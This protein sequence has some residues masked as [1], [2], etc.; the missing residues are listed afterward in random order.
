[1]RYEITSLHGALRPA[2]I[3]SRLWPWYMLGLIG[4]VALWT[5]PYLIALP[6]SLGDDVHSRL[7]RTGF[8]WRSHLL[9]LPGVSPAPD[10]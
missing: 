7:A 9:G 6:G 10:T 4:F 3:T 2:L 5:T 1:M 8:S